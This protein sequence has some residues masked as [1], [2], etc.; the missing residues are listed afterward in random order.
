MAQ[1]QVST[2]PPG[3]KGDSYPAACSCAGLGGRG[4]QKGSVCP[5]YL[6]PSAVIC[7]LIGQWDRDL[8]RS[9][10]F[11]HANILYYFTITF[12]LIGEKNR[13]SKNA[14]G[15]SYLF[16]SLG[17]AFRAMPGTFTASRASRRRLGL[18]VFSHVNAVVQHHLLLGCSRGSRLRQLLQ[19]PTAAAPALGLQASAGVGAA[20]VGGP[21]G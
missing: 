2:A 21:E 7:P 14:A 9:H 11:K 12:F 1:S 4:A 15:I 20:A 13:N 3:Q 5:L 18:D 10:C 19:A 8:S 17:A 6:Q 16:G